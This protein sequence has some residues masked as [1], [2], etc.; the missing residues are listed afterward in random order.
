M[1]G[2]WSPPQELLG[3]KVE[4]GKSLFCWAPPE[5]EQPLS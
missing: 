1:E 3:P 4:L 5:K 2:Q